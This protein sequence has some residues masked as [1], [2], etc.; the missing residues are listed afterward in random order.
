MYL[1]SSSSDKT[2]RRPEAAAVRCSALVNASVHR[3]ADCDSIPWIPAVEHVI[4]VPGVFDIHIIV[5]VPVFCPIFRPR[6]DEAD[7]E[8]AVL[9]AG[10]AANHDQW[11]AVDAEVVVRTKVPAITVLGD[12][13]AVVAAALLPVAVLGLPIMC[14]MLLPDGALLAFLSVLL[15]L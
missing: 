15:L 6:V 4:A 1:R 12:A 2:F 13:V 8:A 14:A 10:I 5:V 7:P 3:D 9:E 11:V